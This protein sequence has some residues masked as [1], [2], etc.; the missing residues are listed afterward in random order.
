MKNDSRPDPAEALR[1]IRELPQDLQDTLFEIL[2]SA[3]GTADGALNT[4]STLLDS[5]V[6]VE[7]HG[8]PLERPAGA[9]PVDRY[10]DLGPIGIGGMGEV[11]RVRDLQLNRVLAMK[12]IH[13]SA[14]GQPGVLERFVEEAHAT[15]QLQHPGVVPVHDLGRLPDGR[16]FFTM[17]EVD[18]RSFRELLNEWDASVPPTPEGATRWGPTLHRKVEVLRQVSAT[19]AFAHDKGLAH[20][21]LKPENILVGRYGEALVVDWGLVK[22]IGGIDGEPRALTDQGGR[23]A[24]RY[25]LVAG[26]P[27]YMPPEQAQGLREVGTAA[28]VYALGA[29]LYEVLTG[30]PPY[31]GPDPIGILELVKSGPPTPITSQ[32][33]P[34]E[35]RDLCERAMSRDPADRPTAAQVTGWMTDWLEGARRT[36]QALELVARADRE[37]VQAEGHV[38]KAEELEARAADLLEGIPTWAEE[39]SKMPAWDLVSEAEELRT[40]A[41]I[42]RVRHQEDLRAALNYVSD[43]PAAHERLA[44]L[45]REA[46]EAAE[47]RK[48]P[49]GEWEN[50]LRRHDRDGRHAAYLSGVGTLD[51]TTEPKG[52]IVHL[53]RCETRGK[54][55]V[56]VLATTGGPTPITRLTMPI[57]SYVL[58]LSH[59]ECHDVRLPVVVHRS[60]T[61]EPRAHHIGLPRKGTLR[62][63]EVYVPAGWFIAGGDE[64]GAS[65]PPGTEIW[66]DAFVIR[67]FPVTNREYIE[68]LD[69]LVARGLEADALDWAPQERSAGS[70]RGT[71]IYGRRP[72]GG[73]ELR[74][75]A[76]GDVWEPDWPVVMVHR[77]CAEA[78][79]SW[80]ATRTGQA[81]RL[82][83]EFEWEKAARGVDGRRYPWGDEVDPSFGCCRFSHPGHP[84]VQPV[85]GF[86]LDVSPYGVRGLGGNVR[87]WCAERWEE[88]RTPPQRL[89]IDPG[90][91]WDS[92]VRYAVR[93]GDWSGPVERMRSDLAD[94]S[95]GSLRNWSVGFRLI[96]SVDERS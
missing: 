50:L 96:R 56:E 1:R 94:W 35:L 88:R 15:A 24:T 55:L 48:H 44:R 78:Y 82:P 65:A 84:V 19:I 61:L 18:G 37:L 58:Q 49:A 9:E 92:T 14:M 41:R 59:V 83:S 74:P 6:P 28:D 70:A 16:A 87:E 76:D 43:L 47:A 30:R 73:F 69:D 52:A 93:G 68:F 54:R 7:G 22:V 53:Y 39:V 62:S 3:S 40:L 57:G 23:F 32:R 46:H 17:R 91:A 63:D 80:E 26:T 33:V 79:A 64:P 11:R 42:G 72:D 34:S 8:A 51:V 38:R 4:I 89:P 12:I 29:L 13:A 67:R 85:M 45:F 60:D 31:D 27:A 75:D 71:M 66:S 95:G 77:G 20:R 86:P 5:A 10:E 36:E 2:D 90:S 25:G 81:W 21:D